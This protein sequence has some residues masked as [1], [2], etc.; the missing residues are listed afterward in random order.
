MRCGGFLDYPRVERGD[1]GL[2]VDYSLL[3]AADSH[4]LSLFSSAL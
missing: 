1:P 4:F 3:A 2:P